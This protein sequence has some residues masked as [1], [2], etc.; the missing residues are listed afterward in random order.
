M[1]TAIALG[2]FKL[3]DMIK[4]NLLQLQQIFPDSPVLM[5][6]DKSERTDDIRKLA[7]EFGHA[8]TGCDVPRGHFA[9]DVQNFVNGLTFAEQE[10]ADIMLK[11]SQRVV[12][13]LPKFKDFIEKPFEDAQI[14]IVVPGRIAAS[15]IS[16][17][18][19]KFFSGF[20][21]LT[22]VVAIRV[23]S[24]APKE[25]LK[26]YTDNFKFGRFSP[27]LL[28]EVFVGQ[29]LATHFSN[30]AY[31]SSDL[32]NHKPMEPMAFLRKAQSN[33][34]NYAQLAKAHGLEG[35]YYPCEEW[36]QLEG[37]NYLCRPVLVT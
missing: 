12:P 10:G 13:V 8:F 25:F 16:M 1:K 35:G 6:D 17:P 34:N 32:A 14:K 27:N 11:L 28:V 21:I 30:S 15:Q 5:S 33:A 36:G 23:G 4:L 18:A 24:I 26:R 19:S 31:I 20:G 7:E 37:K 22:D 3:Y 9:G 2:T 29:L